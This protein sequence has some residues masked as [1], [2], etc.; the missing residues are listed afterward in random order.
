MIDIKTIPIDKLLNDLLITDTDVIT[1]VIE[2]ELCRRF[3][4]GDLAIKAMQEI[5]SLL[6]MKDPLPY[7]EKVYETWEEEDKKHS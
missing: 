3:N 1:D 6:N 7:I 4:R 2:K 5:K